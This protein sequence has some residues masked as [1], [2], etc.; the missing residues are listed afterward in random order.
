MSVH[1]EYAPCSH[2]SRVS[3]RNDVWKPTRS[4]S[5]PQVVTGL[6]G[7]QLQL[8]SD[9]Y[10]AC[11]AAFLGAMAWLMVSCELLIRACT[12]HA[13]RVCAAGELGAERAH[14]IWQ[15]ANSCEL[16]WCVRSLR[17]C[18]HRNQV[19]Q[20]ATMVCAITAKLSTSQSSD[21]VDSQQRRVCRVVAYS[22]PF[23]CAGG[24]FTGTWFGSPAATPQPA[25]A[26][27]PFAGIPGAAVGSS[28]S[29]G[30]S[31]VASWQQA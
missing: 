20:S 26:A 1:Q 7:M 8:E 10:L 17:S 28:H 25:V 12:V 23:R 3:R 9:P 21:T 24:V 14:R 15:Q 31:G 6:S 5:E 29:S 22:Q 4:R 27:V 19:T 11:S 13:L 2:G 30:S 18:Q 16:R